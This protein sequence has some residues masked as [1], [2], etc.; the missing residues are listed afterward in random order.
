MSRANF[1]SVFPR[2]VEEIMSHLKSL[3]MAPGAIE[4]YR[5]NL[6]HNTMGGKLNRGLAVVETCS[7]LRGRELRK[8]EYFDAAILGW[9]VELLQAFFLV[10]DDMMDES[11]TRRG[12]PCWYLMPK[13]GNIAINDSFMLESAIFFLLKSHFRKEAWYV[14]VVELFHDVRVECSSALTIGYLPN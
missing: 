4:W 14:D 6:M 11:K 13:V 3:E 1:E 9:C 2:L 5:E 7:I 12:Q 8:Q 10:A